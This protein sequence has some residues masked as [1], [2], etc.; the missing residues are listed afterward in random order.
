MVEFEDL[1]SRHI[2]YVSSCL[3]NQNRRYPGIAVCQGAVQELVEPLM[4]N[5][6]G[7]EQ[8]PCLECL[9]W[10]GVA[11]SSVFR[12][13]PTF[14]RSSGSRSFPLIRRFGRL[15]LW[16]YVRLC[17]KR[18]RDVVRDIR[19]YRGHGYKILSIIGMNDSPTCGV[20]KTI[21]MLELAGRLKQLGFTHDDLAAPHIDRMRKAMQSV[22][23]DG[24]GCF[25]KELTRKLDQEGIIVPILGFDAWADISSEADR[26]I[27]AVLEK[28][29][30]A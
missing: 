8:L 25:M 3:L 15:W 1:R 28:T 23:M 19:D 22:L 17:R 13:L 7:I 20:T 4:K 26:V 24:Q 9:G 14:Y 6:I 29:E 11:R 21:D 27:R 5:G 30:C 2:V 16:K 10:G 18:A 12:F